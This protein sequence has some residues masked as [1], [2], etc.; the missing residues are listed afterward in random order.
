MSSYLEKATAY[1]ASKHSVMGLTQVL[2]VEGRERGVRAMALVVGR[3][4]T[5]SSALSTR[6]P[7]R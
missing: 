4:W 1:A 5:N 3:M 7:A 6:R 2:H